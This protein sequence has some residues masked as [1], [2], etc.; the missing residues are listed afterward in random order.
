[1]HT[2]LHPLWLRERAPVVGAFDPSNGQR[3]YDPCDLNEHF[4]VR[5]HA[6]VGDVLQVV[7]TDGCEADFPVDQI[8]M[9]LG[10]KQRA[11]APPAPSHW[12]T[13]N[14]T[15]SRFSWSTLSD[16]TGPEMLDALTAFFR[17]GWIVVSNV[18]TVVG[19]VVDVANHFG[20][21][22]PSAFGTTF[23]VQ[24]KPNPT[25]LAYTGLRLAAH[26]DQP[27]R[28]PVAGIQMLHA[29]V[30][31]AVGGDSTLVDGSAAVAALA[32]ADPEA[33]SALSELEVE[34]V[35]DTPSSVMIDRAPII[36][37][38]AAGRFKQLRYS[39]RLDYVESAAPPRLDA[40]YR[41]RRWLRDYFA[42]DT[43]ELT[44][45]LE[46]G[47]V[48]IMD[49]HRLLHGRTAF[50]ANTGPRH[51]EGC[52]IDHERIDTLYRLAYRRNQLGLDISG[53]EL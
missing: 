36:A 34:F 17:F 21:L 4:G 16:Q 3:L 53:E 5:H 43:N 18:P 24:S 48:L 51:L 26:T 42:D 49:N 11:D 25:D 31:G 41:G 15:I 45:R 30:N 35:Y 27:Y 29:I 14:A 13:A 20:F 8:A 33:F 6:F 19:S 12:S 23:Q 39:T 40:F 2:Q 50:D 22:V 10:W 38:D 1:M 46:A 47:E 37:L 7:F 32:S 9:W 28:K 52:Y 44:F